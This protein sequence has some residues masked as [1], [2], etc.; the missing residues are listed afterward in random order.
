MN[1]DKSMFTQE[2]SGDKVTSQPLKSLADNSVFT[3]E[4]SGKKPSLAL[5]SSVF[6]QELSNK[7]TSMFSVVAFPL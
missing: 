2:L 4:L 5:N 1:L 7:A 6:T 3:Q